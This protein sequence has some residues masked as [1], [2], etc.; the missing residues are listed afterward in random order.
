MYLN[1]LE[2]VETVVFNSKNVGENRERKKVEY[3]SFVSC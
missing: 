2:S 1:R 3:K